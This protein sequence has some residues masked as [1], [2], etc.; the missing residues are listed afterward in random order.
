M[1]I[2][3]GH[4]ESMGF[5]PQGG[6]N[7]AGLWA[8]EGL[9]LVQVLTGALWP[10]QGGQTVRSEDGSQGP[11]GRPCWSRWA[12]MRW[13]QV[14]AEEGGEVGGFWICFEGRALGRFPGGLDVGGE[15]KRGVTGDPKDFGLYTWKDEAA[16]MKGSRPRQTGGRG[17]NIPGLELRV[18]PSWHGP[19]GVL[20]TP[21]EEGQGSRGH[22][23]MKRPGGRGGIFELFPGHVGVRPRE[24]KGGGCPRGPSI[25]GTL[26][27]RSRE[28]CQSWR[29]TGVQGARSAGFRARFQEKGSKGSARGRP[30]SS[31]G[32]G[33]VPRLGRPWRPQGQDP[34]EGW[35]GA[36][37]AVPGEATRWQVCRLPAGG[38]RGNPWGASALPP[39]QSPTHYPGSGD[40]W[41]LGCTFPKKGF[42]ALTS[43]STLP[44]PL[45]LSIGS[46]HTAGI[47]DTGAA[48]RWAQEPGRGRGEPPGRSPVEPASP[49][50]SRE[51]RAPPAPGSGRG[52]AADAPGRRVTAPRLPGNGAGRRAGGA[53]ARGVG[54]AGLQHAP[55]AAE[56]SP[57]PHLRAGGALP[58]PPPGPRIH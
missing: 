58:R 56:G 45:A 6:G 9:D 10:L 21:G 44:R 37:G 38:K 53:A 13:D 22:L 48:R 33:P 54:A 31:K 34:G 14:E 18:R 51:A 42:R 23:P 47:H 24:T 55:R 29:G 40:R 35:A 49:L 36:G 20:S 17:K 26:P 2:P 50:E 30:P 8:E 15:T 43:F 4:G 1:Q 57:P 41:N 3:V 27:Q 5:Y 11:Q 52:R 25:P 32:E 46:R 12:M 7:L 28:A 19:G 39:P 16:V